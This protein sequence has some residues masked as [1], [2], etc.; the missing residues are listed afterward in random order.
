MSPWL[1]FPVSIL[2]TKLIIMK[3]QINQKKLFLLSS[4]L[5]IS[6]IIIIVSVLAYLGYFRQN[7]PSLYLA[8]VGADDIRGQGNAR[9]IRL[10][11]EDV[12]AQGGIQGHPIELLTF[13]DKNQRTEALTQAQNV[14]DDGRVLAVLGHFFSSTSLAGSGIYEKHEIPAITASATSDAVTESEWYFRVI[15]NNYSQ[16]TFLAN[17]A[18]QVLKIR[19][20][21]IVYVEDAYGKSLKEAFEETALINGI[22]IPKIWSYDLNDENID[23]SLTTIVEEIL[24]LEEPGFIF[25]ATHSRNGFKLIKPLKDR[26]WDQTIMGGDG[27]ISN[28]SWAGGL[29]YAEDIFVSA[30]II[31]DVANEKA[32]IFQLN[33]F[34]RYGEDPSGFDQGYYDATSLII[35]AL[36]QM[37]LSAGPEARPEIRKQIRDFL[38]KRNSLENAIEGVT[39]YNYFDKQGDVVKPLSV[40][41]YK[42]KKLISAL[43]QLS[44]VPDIDVIPD[45]ETALD[46]EQIIKINESHMF[47]T[48]VV[49]T[50][51]DVLSLS[52]YN[53]REST[54]L[55][56]FYLWFRFRGEFEDTAIEFPTAVG[57]I[58]LQTPIAED[59]TDDVSFRAYRV[60]GKFRA[61]FNFQDYPFDQHILRVNFRHKDLQK[62]NL[63]YVIDELG[64]NPTG[65]ENIDSYDLNL[66]EFAKGW[67][68]EDNWYYQDLVKISSTLGNPL[69]FKTGGHQEY[70]RFNWALE[71]KR[72]TVSFIMKNLFPVFIIILII[73]LIYYIPPEQFGIRISIGVNGLLTL[74]FFNLKLANDLPQ[75]SYLVAMEYIF[76]VLYL[77]VIFS[78]FITILGHLK[79]SQEKM[80]SLNRVSTTGKIIHPVVIVVT[81]F[82]VVWHYFLQY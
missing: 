36:K 71:I 35:E 12:N 70:S 45:L 30:P 15:F 64:M 44:T 13:D 6:A 48:K 8:Y 43:T 82:V 62:E 68:I 9:A 54:F 38:V 42:D 75:I 63:I 76:Y 14:V 19:K 77:L 39:G 32:Q 1:P 26:G 49:Y 41:V 60:K 2:D 67:V 10:L 58:T 23:A 5:S 79:L 65:V 57:E 81:I 73:Y 16:G 80:V 51:M 47:K 21:R 33:Y 66:I 55:M 53:E 34:L 4:L 52:N 28:T 25:F 59:T 20:A 17:Y 61:D 72:D 11:L 78:M 40:G 27:L 69:L 31:S 37:K 7:K 24:S 18:H 56:D 22:E 46:K 50:G 3:S 74:A 29:E